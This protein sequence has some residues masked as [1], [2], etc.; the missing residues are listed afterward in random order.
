MHF[1][2]MMSTYNSTLYVLHHQMYTG[3]LSLQYRPLYILAYSIS[4]SLSTSHTCIHA[5]M[6]THMTG[7]RAQN[8]DLEVQCAPGA[9]RFESEPYIASPKLVNQGEVC[10][11][12]SRKV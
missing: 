2:C 3:V 11:L 4:T 7:P 9:S 6:Y 10:W 12:H 5:C 8:V 1:Q